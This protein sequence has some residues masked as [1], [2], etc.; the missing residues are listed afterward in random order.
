MLLQNLNDIDLIMSSKRST[1]HSQ[2]IFWNSFCPIRAL[3][4][5]FRQDRMHLFWSICNFDFNLLFKSGYQADQ[6]LSKWGCIIELQSNL[7]RVGDKNLLFL[8]KNLS[9]LLILFI[10][11]KTIDS[12]ERVSCNEQPRYFSV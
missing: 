5:K 8:N 9:L 1:M 10:T 2:L 6:A 3:L 7:R 12:P 4:F 11:F